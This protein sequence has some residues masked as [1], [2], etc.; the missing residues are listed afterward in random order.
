MALKDLVKFVTPIPVVDPGK[1]VI[2]EMSR[3]LLKFAQFV[4]PDIPPHIQTLIQSTEGL[5]T[6]RYAELPDWK[7]RSPVHNYARDFVR[8]LVIVKTGL[9]I[10][11]LSFIEEL[12]GLRLDLNFSVR[13]REGTGRK[14]PL[15]SNF[16]WSWHGLACQDKLHDYLFH[17]I[18]NLILDGLRHEM[19]ES[20]LFR[21]VRIFDPH[22]MKKPRPF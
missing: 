20:I 21:G 17:G 12:E 15:E 1:D 2:E 18:R 11:A 6:I 16:M 10:T 9:P 13:D 22:G 3:D 5:V 14:I 8:D 4:F 19:D 7:R